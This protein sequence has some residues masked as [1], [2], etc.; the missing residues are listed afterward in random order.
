MELCQHG[1]SVMMLQPVLAAC[2]QEFAHPQARFLHEKRAS[3]PPRV[4][5]RLQLL[6]GAVNRATFKAIDS[7]MFVGTVG[8]ASSNLLLH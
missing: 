7:A 3:L 6:F 4:Q 5:R 8:C 2:A 1:M